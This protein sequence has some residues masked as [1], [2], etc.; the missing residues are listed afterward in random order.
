MKSNPTILH[1]ST[2]PT[3]RG[4]EQ[5][6]AYLLTELKNKAINHI[7]ICPVNSPMMKFCQE[8]NIEF[9]SYVRKGALSFKAAKIIKDLSCRVDVMHAHDAHAHSLAYLSSILYSVVTPLVIH[10]RVIFP[11]KNKFFTRKKYA[12]QNLAKVISISK[13]VQT[14][15]RTYGVAKEKLALIHSAIDANK[16]SRESK[17]KLRT[18]YHVPTDDHVIGYVA[19]LTSEKDQTTFIK[20]AQQLLV[21][22]LEATFF[23]IGAGRDQEQLESLIAE[24]G[25]QAKIII[26][27]FRNDIPDILPELDLFLFTSTKEGL[28]TSVLDAFASGVP[29]VATD[30]GGIRDIIHHDKTGL[31][32]AVGDV[33]ALVQ[34]VKRVVNDPELRKRLIENSQELL[35][36][37]NSNTMATKTLAL[38]KEIL[39][40]NTNSD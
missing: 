25:L 5:Q 15:C 11:I 9:F 24:L 37:F 29:V 2:A 1:I 36:Q 22:K 40:D 27:G 7:V 20:T 38:Y 26:T 35:Q 18:E 17:H 13:E 34:Q 8:N 32:T 6:L 21:D 10:R 23:L 14:I 30:S 39:D 31:M 12:M 33:P 28:G 19:A 16:F 3:W 4:G